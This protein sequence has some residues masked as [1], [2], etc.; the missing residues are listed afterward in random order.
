MQKLGNI[1]ATA[2]CWVVSGWSPDVLTAALRV[3]AAQEH[4]WTPLPTDPDLWKRSLILL[5]IS[6]DLITSTSQ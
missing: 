2:G 4:G 1:K 5:F 3:T 6:P